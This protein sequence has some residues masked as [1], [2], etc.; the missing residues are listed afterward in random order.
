[1]MHADGGFG[2]V[3]LAE[4]GRPDPRPDRQPDRPLVTA[5]VESLT[6]RLEE[7]KAFFPS[8]AAELDT[9]HDR[10]P[11]DPEY[12]DY[13][14]LDAAGQVLLVTVRRG[15]VLIGYFVGFVRP[16]LH[17]RST[18]TALQDIFYVL[19]TAR[20]GSP[21]AAL[22]L[23]RV[24]IDECRRRGVKELRLGC[25]V[26]HDVSRLFEHFGAIEVER[27]WSIWLGDDHA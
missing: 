10:R 22:K 6:A 1:M 14:R 8:H 21:T 20:D 25:K 12:A 23:F 7:L 16:A 5:Q 17:Y 4:E 3:H 19:P 13:L 26:A 15:G 2:R 27:I 18:L 11:L 24:V 9:Y